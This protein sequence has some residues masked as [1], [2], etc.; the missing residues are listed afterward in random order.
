MSRRRRAAGRAATLPAADA[1]RRAA[2]WWRHGAAG[3]ALV[4]A[5]TTLAFARVTGHGFLN[6][7]DPDV[8]LRNAPLEGPHVA[9]WAFSTT[10]MGHYQPLSWLV[11]AGLRRLFGPDPFAHHLASLLGHL[12]DAALVYWLAFRL[13]APAAGPARLLAAIGAALLFAVHPLRV[14]PVAWASG[15][16]YVLALAP[17][18]LATLAYLHYATRPGARRWLLVSV[19]AY[20]ASLLFRPVALGFP[21]VLA[22]LDGWLARRGARHVTLRRAVLEKLPFATLAVAAFALEARAR[23]FV[24]LERIG[25]EARLADAALAP[26]VYLLRT[27]AP[28]GLSPLDPLPLEARVSWPAL[29]AG[30][31]LLAVVTTITVRERARQPALVLAWF[32]YLALLA[33]ALGLAPSGLQATA[34]RYA[35]LPGVV[36]ALAAGAGLGAL[37]RARPREAWIVTAAAGVLLAVATA[38]LAGHWR[39]SVSLWSRAVAI[40]RRNDVALYNLASA[41]DEAGRDVEAAAR[42]RELLALLPEHGPARRNLAVLE[43]RGFEEQA[44]ALAAGGRLAEASDLYGRALTLDP[45]RLHSRASRGMALATM[46][47]FAEAVPD[48]EA[49]FAA[50]RTEPAVAGALVWA[51]IETGQEASA[52]QVLERA[53]AVNPGEARL[54]ELAARLEKKKPRGRASPG[55]NRPVR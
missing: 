29:L 49:A 46:G 36:V 53:L 9:R 30:V 11:W 37:S 4:L 51:L 48:L 40:D 12:L 27:V 15:L 28:F 44:N 17:L 47:R 52:R 13:A 25:L 7:D 45:A 18:L 23:A 39:G 55:R 10:H 31:V 6:W 20:L 43:A 50:G 5:L 19:A 35:Y 22:L 41:L 14:E 3:L 34:D 26:F 42:Y 54:A 21:L 16:P 24:G 1:S 33:P 8:L 2:P 38:S 32:S